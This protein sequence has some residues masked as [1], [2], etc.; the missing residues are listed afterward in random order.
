VLVGK[1]LPVLAQY[2][3]FRGG[4]EGTEDRVESFLVQAEQFTPDNC[5]E[6]QPAPPALTAKKLPILLQEPRHET[7][8]LRVERGPLPLRF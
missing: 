6:R 2:R 4:R 8:A 1:L 7:R 3:R 5:T